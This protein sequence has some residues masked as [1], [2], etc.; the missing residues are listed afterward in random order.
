MFFPINF[1]L[2]QITNAFSF[3]VRL[4]RCHYFPER[5]KKKGGGVIISRRLCPSVPDLAV[6]NGFLITNRNL[7]FSFNAKCSAGAFCPPAPRREHCELP[8]PRAP[9]FEVSGPNNNNKKI[10]TKQSNRTTTSARF[11]FHWPPLQGRPAVPPPGRAVTALAPRGSSSQ[12]P[13]L[14]A[15]GPPDR[16]P[17]ALFSP[18]GVSPSSPRLP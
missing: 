14:L 5:K 17:R 3:C 12:P 13:A 18:A 7:F 4:P 1:S 15:A 11:A 8:E 16:R 6:R 9:R 2:F 10:C